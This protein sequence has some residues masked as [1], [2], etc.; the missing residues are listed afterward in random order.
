MPDAQR[1]LDQLHSVTRDLEEGEMEDEEDVSKATKSP[2]SPRHNAASA[3]PR[4]SR[5]AYGPRDV[6]PAQ[7]AAG[8]YHGSS[9]SSAARPLGAV[10]G[11]RLSG[12]TGRAPPSAPRALRQT[13]I[14]TVPSTPTTVKPRAPPTGPRG[15][16]RS[17]TVEGSNHAGG[18]PEA[19][20]ADGAR[21]HK[22]RRRELEPP[23]VIVSDPRDVELGRMR[24]VVR[25]KQRRIDDLQYELAEAQARLHIYKTRGADQDF[26]IT[27]RE[28]ITKKFYKRN[29][30]EDCKDNWRIQ[31]LSDISDEE[32]ANGSPLPQ[33]AS[34][35]P[36][37]VKH[38]ALIP[39]EGKIHTAYDIADDA[40]FC[41]DDEHLAAADSDILA[42]AAAQRRISRAEV[43]AKAGGTE[44]DAARQ[45]AREQLVAKTALAE[46]G[47]RFSY[48]LL[49]WQENGSWLPAPVGRFGQPF[50]QGSAWEHFDPR[51]LF[52]KERPDYVAPTS[53]E[54]LKLAQDAS[55]IS[56]V[57][58]SATQRQVVSWA[59]QRGVGFINSNEP[60]MV[61]MCRTNPARLPT[62]IRRH[63]RR[64]RSDALFY[65]EYDAGD[66]GNHIVLSMSGPQK[67]QDGLARRDYHEQKRSWLQLLEACV[68]DWV[69][70]VAE[71]LREPLEFATEVRPWPTGVDLV[72]RSINDHELYTMIWYH[73][74]A[75][76][77]PPRSLRPGGDCHDY[78]RRGR[79]M[80]QE[81]RGLSEIY[82]NRVG[83]EHE[84]NQEDKRRWIADRLPYEPVPAGTPIVRVRLVKEKVDV[85]AQKYRERRNEKGFIPL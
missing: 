15:S 81:R 77:L 56:F 40:S 78:I 11:D 57:F 67:T 48:V 58:R 44:S 5:P 54:F 59:L 35:A 65:A 33:T 37:R 71:E 47:L 17:P 75:N 60:D 79:I 10:R 52:D 36:Q 76:G 74:T 14:N 34:A 43:A 61:S 18:Q 46:Y 39:S 51:R 68:L 4:D 32:A 83:P 64:G 16:R 62:A 41:L 26:D 53:K 13:H 8:A 19:S 1:D 12:G 9:A 38:D 3:E 73:L 31:E 66:V 42:G 2:S 21:A 80:E 63:Y 24:E 7:R 82:D 30:P 6:W 69:P 70:V 29:Y 85:L 45:L 84:G 50:W 28:R 20:P 49:L 55:L 72:N 27:L 25:Q 22:R 23:E